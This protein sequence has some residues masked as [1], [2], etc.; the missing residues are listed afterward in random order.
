MVLRQLRP[1]W[2][3]FIEHVETL[4]SGI[5]CGGRHHVA[6]ELVKHPAS[7]KIAIWLLLVSVSATLQRVQRRFDIGT[8]AA[9]DGASSCSSAKWEHKALRILYL[10]RAMPKPQL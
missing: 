1:H 3:A 8:G 10:K 9:L 5:G 4:H 7:A 6:D 2:C